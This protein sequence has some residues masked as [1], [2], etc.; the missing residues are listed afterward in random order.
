MA[1]AEH[2]E[3][4]DSSAPPYAISLV[5]PQGAGQEWRAVVED[6]V[7]CEARGRTP[8]E[9]VSR[10]RRAIAEWISEAQRDGRAVPPPRGRTATPDAAHT[11]RLMVRMPPSLHAEL[12]HLADRERVALNTLIIAALGGAVGWKAS[13]DP[14]DGTDRVVAAGERALRRRRGGGDGE[15]R[16]RLL[17]LAVTTNI[18]VVAVTGLVAIGLIIVALLS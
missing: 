12:A 6:L 3:A 15:D 16:W 14:R 17:S 5:P 13:G 8:E 18:V 9:A 11:G 2:R 4:A 7:G 1:V 10:T